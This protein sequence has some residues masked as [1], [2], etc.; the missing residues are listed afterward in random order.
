MRGIR[1]GT[2]KCGSDRR[3]ITLNV[4]MVSWVYTYVK[5]ITLYTYCAY[6]MLLYLNK[7]ALKK[8]KRK[9]YKDQITYELL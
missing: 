4:I 3:I 6:C 9:K 8:E 2:R 5:L 7:V 1:K